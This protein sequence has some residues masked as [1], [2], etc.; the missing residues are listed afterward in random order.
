[1]AF[2]VFENLSVLRVSVWTSK[3]VLRT[4]VQLCVCPTSQSGD[5]TFQGESRGDRCRA[6]SEERED[7][8]RQNNGLAGN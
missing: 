1:M 8:L 2:T 7:V 6:G 3:P 4:M 5:E